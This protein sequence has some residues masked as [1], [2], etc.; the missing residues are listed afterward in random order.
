MPAGRSS[1]WQTLLLDAQVHRLA[2]ELEPAVAQQRAG[3]QVRLGQDLEPVADAEDRAARLGEAHD[4][5]HDRAEARD[6]AAADV[7]A[8]GEAARQHDRVEAGEVG[9]AVPDVLGLEAEVAA[10]RG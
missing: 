9:V 1:H 4:L 5:G 8:V 6:G 2:D 3:Q 7:V 10:S